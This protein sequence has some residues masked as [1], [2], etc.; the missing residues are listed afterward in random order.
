MR[1]CLIP[2]LVILGGLVAAVPVF[3]HH[4]FAAEYDIN[5]PV[6]LKGTLT[7]M[8]WVNPHGWIYISVK[9]DGGTVQNWA[10]EFGAPTSLL[11]R[12][13]RKTDFPEGIEVTVNGYRAK[14][15]TR[16]VNGSSVKLPDGRTLLTG[17][18]S[19]DTKE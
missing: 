18:S 2:R 8:E 13:L 10:I 4:S 11:K 16:T 12:G 6:T 9:D 3:A 5:K 19:G 14:N 17:S 1:K 7:K 15:G